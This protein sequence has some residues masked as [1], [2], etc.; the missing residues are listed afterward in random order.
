MFSIPAILNINTDYRVVYCFIGISVFCVFVTLQ[1][2]TSKTMNIILYI[3]ILIIALIAYKYFQGQ[4]TNLKV[5]DNILGKVETDL[6]NIYDIESKDVAIFKLMMKNDP[7]Q[8]YAFKTILKFKDNNLEVYTNL[9]DY[10][11]K[12]FTLY[13]KLLRGTSSV[14]TEFQ[15]LLDRRN[16]MLQ[17]ANMLY[18]NTTYN[19]HKITLEKLYLILQSSTYKYVNIIKN[20]YN[21]QDF[22]ILPNES[23]S[24]RSFL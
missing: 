15:T 14:H 17:Y 21:L 8:N 13:R 2:S 9:I 20:K 1:N 4:K 6:N 24:V 3:N 23:L 12:F 22:I 5:V 19:I 10:M 7:Y 11:Y 16:T 18:F